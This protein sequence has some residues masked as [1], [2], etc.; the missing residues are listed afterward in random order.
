MNRAEIN[1]DVKQRCEDCVLEHGSV[2][3]AMRSIEKELDEYESMWSK[4]SG[5]GLGQAID[6][7]TMMIERLDNLPKEEVKLLNRRS[8]IKKILG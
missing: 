6:C 4:Y 2:K 5:D 8:V 3:S 1:Y 7:L